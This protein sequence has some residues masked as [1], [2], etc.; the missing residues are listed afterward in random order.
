MATQSLVPQS[1]TVMIPCRACNEQGARVV[2]DSEGNKR[3]VSCDVCGGYGRKPVVAKEC[4][5]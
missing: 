4:G 3:A 2:V 5:G 1:D